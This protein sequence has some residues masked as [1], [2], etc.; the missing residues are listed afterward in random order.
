MSSR[1]SLWFVVASL[2]GIVLSASPALTQLG[3][4]FPSERRVVEDP[5][6]GVPLTFLTSTPKGDSKIYPTHPQWTSDGEWLIFRSNRVPGEAMAVHEQ[7]GDLVQ[8]T[9]G[10]YM[11]MLAI[12]K[13]SMKLYVMRDPS[14]TPGQGGGGGPRGDVQVVEID[15]ARLFDDSAAGRMQAKASYERVVGTIPAAMDAAGDMAID[16]DE[17]VIYL[18][19]G[20]EYAARHLP[21]G[22][23]PESTFGP[24]NMGAGPTALASMDLQTGEI[25]HVVSVPFQMGHV[26]ANPWVPGEIIFCWETGGN[27]PTRMW[28]VMADGSGLRPVYR[29]P[30]TD[31]VTH[32]AVISRDEVVFA[33]MGHRRVG[34]D[35]EWGIAGSREFPT[36]LAIINLRTNEMRIA[37]QTE[38]GSG[39]WHVH[40]S[41]DG[42]WAVGDDFDRNIYL[43]DRTS[44]ELILLSTGHKESAQDHP[45][46]T[47]SPDGTKIHIQ[48]AMLSE[49]DR[50]MN[51]VII[52]VPQHLL[53]RTYIDRLVP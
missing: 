44:D 31:W 4:R 38:S 39:L 42:R 41:P 48:S 14:R 3:A 51:M 25:R 45:H 26:Q 18:R 17:D 43:I 23:E 37:G 7:T 12:A 2:C 47:F 28:T 10:G 34:V 40:G 8:V 15:L 50:S 46:P 32:E 19:V 52:P 1:T 49:D 27:A 9:E 21:P 36:G 29:E 30:E 35:D 20:R 13:K 5:V 6:T 53:D 33:I 16:A 22:I 24:R 11:G